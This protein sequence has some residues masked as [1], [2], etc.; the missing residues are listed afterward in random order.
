VE[1]GALI[2]APGAAAQQLHADFRRDGRQ[3][4]EPPLSGATLTAAN[5]PRP[6]MPPRLVT[7]VYLQDAPGA[8]FGA[9]AFVPYT[10]NAAAHSVA[11]NP[12]NTARIAP[13]RAFFSKGEEGGGVP[14]RIPLELA[15][16][17]A[18]DAV[19]YDASV[20]HFGCSN[21]V[22]GNERAV[23]YFGVSRRGA[24]ALCAGPDVPWREVAERVQLGDWTGTGT[25]TGTGI[26]SSSSES[27]ASNSTDQS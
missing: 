8:E 24:A 6:D 3:S 22:P 4:V 17:R 1:C 21:E 20:L 7:F 15:A 10:S 27:N 23:F 11:L 19:V 13:L 25:G 18:G 12:D 16:L 26:S 9:T 2:A 5:A 14:A